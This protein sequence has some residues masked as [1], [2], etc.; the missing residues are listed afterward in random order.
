MTTR[1]TH[2]GP[3][4]QIPLVRAL[5]VKVLERAMSP[6]PLPPLVNAMDWYEGPAEALYM[7][8]D[9]R[10]SAYAEIGFQQIAPKS[11]AELVRRRGVRAICHHIYGPIEQELHLALHDMW[12]RGLSSSDPVVRRIERLI[13]V[14]RG[15]D[16]T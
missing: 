12:E 8:Q 5:K 6:P 1:E 9:L 11:A 16:Q 13:C 10:F 2:I 15:E 3:T 4:P 7:P 14:L